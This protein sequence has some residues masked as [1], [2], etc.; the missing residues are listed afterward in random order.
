MNLSFDRPEV[1]VGDPALEC[2]VHRSGAIMAKR[3]FSVGAS[4][5]WETK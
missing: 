4:R 1:E 5:L 2:A 3:L